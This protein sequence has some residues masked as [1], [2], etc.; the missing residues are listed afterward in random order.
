MNQD[1]AGKLATDA[2]RLVGTRPNVKHA[3]SRFGEITKNDSKAGI[4]QRQNFGRC[5]LPHQYGRP[6]AVE[7]RGTFCGRRAR[8]E[9][10]ISL[11]KAI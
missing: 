4:A 11:K 2:W 10:G 5:R 7:I 1:E 6:H 9:T 3:V 8:R